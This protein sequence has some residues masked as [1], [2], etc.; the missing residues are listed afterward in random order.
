MTSNNESMEFCCG[1][2]LMHP[3]SIHEDLDSIPGLPQWVKDP[4][5][6]VSCGVD[7]RLSLNPALLWLWRKLA[8]AAPI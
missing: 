2:A 7:G 4:V 1:S 8:T 3:T 5:V 6:V